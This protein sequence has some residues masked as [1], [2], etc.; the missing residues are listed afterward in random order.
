MKRIRK[1][2]P[3]LLA[4][5]PLAGANGQPAAPATAGANGTTNTTTQAGNIY[6]VSLYDGSAS[7][8]IPIYAY[9]VDG[10]DL[11]VSLNYNTKGI[12]LDQISGSCGLGWSLLPDY[13]ITR[14]VNGVPDEMELPD[15]NYKPNIPNGLGGYHDTDKEGFYHMDEGC[16]GND[17]DYDRDA[18]QDIFYASLPGRN[19]R[20]CSG[21]VSGLPFQVFPK[22]EVSV[23]GGL[24]AL[25]GFPSYFLP[26]NGRD[27][28]TTRTYFRITDEKG[29]QFIFNKVDYEKHWRGNKDGRNN[30]EYYQ[31]SK[32]LLTSIVTYSGKLITFHY[33]TVY[34]M[35]FPQYREQQVLEQK[36]HNEVASDGTSTH[37][38]AAIKVLADSN[39]L[40]KGTISYLA[41]IVYPN[42]TTVYFNYETDAN[43][44]R[45]DLSNG[46][47]LTS[48][49]VQSGYDANTTNAF[50]YNL[51][52][53]YFHSPSTDTAT[54]LSYGI[55]CNSIGNINYG[56]TSAPQD[57]MLGLRLKLKSI[58]KT[59][60]DNITKERYY[61]FDY[62][63]TAMKDRLSPSKDY[64]GYY[65]G[66]WPIYQHI[67]N[68]IDSGFSTLFYTYN[69]A[70]PYH[71]FAPGS[72]TSYVYGT[73][74]DPVFNNMQAW[75]LTHVTNGLG[76]TVNLYY[77]MHDLYNP[78]NAYNDG[79]QPAHRATDQYGQ[80]APD[81]LCIDSILVK[82]GYNADN[83]TSYKYVFEHGERFFRGGYFWE[84]K[85]WDG[86]AGN[87][88]QVY[89][90]YFYNDF[91]NPMQFINGA[92]HGYS[93]ATVKDYGYNNQFL[94]AT[95]YHFSNL[96]TEAD[97]NVS[98]LS[99]QSYVYD[100]YANH[101]KYD[102]L[103]FHRRHPDSL[104][105]YNMGQVL[106]SFTYNQAWNL[107]AQ[108][109]N[110]YID[111]GKSFAY[112][113][114]VQ[115]L[116]FNV[117]MKSGQEVPDYYY[118]FKSK[119]A[120]LKS[121]TTTTYANGQSSATTLTNDF[122]SNDNITTVHWQDS[123]GDYYHKNYG[124]YGQFM[125]AS[126]IIKDGTGEVVAANFSG[127]PATWGAYND[128]HSMKMAA[129]IA[130]SSVA[131]NDGTRD[132][133]HSFDGSANPIQT[134]YETHTRYDA[135]FWDMRIGQKVADITNAQYNDVAYTSFEGNFGPSGN[136]N[137]K[138]NWDFDSS[139]VVYTAPTATNRAMTGHY[140]YHIS[141]SGSVTS[142]IIPRSTQQY[143]LSFWSQNAG[144]ATINGTSIQ[145]TNVDI[146]G[147]W[148][149]RT[150]TFTGDD[151]HPVVISGGLSNAYID[152]L[153]LC[154][155]Q[156]T[157]T[158]CTYEP[159][160]GKGSACNERNDI[161]YYEYD[162]MGRV[163]VVR[164]IERNIISLTK[165]T[166]QG[167]D[168]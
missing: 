58:D 29:N 10:L 166:V 100:N 19:L 47:V 72:G 12:Q 13:S 121:S 34:N 138:G 150:G 1:L 51:N 139:L 90:Q 82:D 86:L 57:P 73:P 129:P 35:S 5:I 98:N 6:N 87:G 126:T 168:Y 25:P 50:T 131:W 99:V 112:N 120:L 39:V 8:N 160:L 23:V 52:Y 143:R 62:N 119:K 85:Y 76:G 94:G 137:N 84:P 69:A 145:L 30:Y 91:I 15:V 118:P 107:V 92:N 95:K 146:A 16:W 122:D 111:S 136:I 64:Y 56:N 144:G 156:S 102:S 83:T 67:G 78:A 11:G 164:D 134:D 110:T 148:I 68:T 40:W 133:F 140:V 130:Q 97:S 70:I 141:G 165:Q 113:S 55:A 17:Y 7:I 45:C 21:T 3:L 71:I 79:D 103:L 80:N 28:T 44:P 114:P 159:L 46:K 65:N 20:F 116:A 54:E 155:V 89:A 142:A 88:V 74:K 154:P 152:E 167:S 31:S 163:K 66:S 75:N 32:W 123:K 27:D 53:A 77:K 125:N 41:D 4:V 153:R 48:I 161:V 81:G 117:G 18:D 104:A 37:F 115:K 14:Q 24:P 49:K 108:T 61:S 109:Q 132:K 36:D 157:M 149:L 93:F 42:G 60:T 162:A 43:K 33:T 22:S 63:K 106:E 158:T 9:A 59:G 101:V 135:A 124:Y 147:G 96:M 128:F 127:T 2:I 151:V 105:E 26:I 38:N